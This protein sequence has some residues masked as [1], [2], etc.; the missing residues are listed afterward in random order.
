MPTFEQLQQQFQ[1]EMKDHR[2]LD[3]ELKD[4]AKDL[5]DAA[6]NLKTTSLHSRQQTTSMI[7]GWNSL[8]QSIMGLTQQIQAM[9]LH[10]RSQEVKMTGGLMPSFGGGMPTAPGFGGGMQTRPPVMQGSGM[11][12]GMQMLGGA[13]AGFGFLKDQANAPLNMS[14]FA[15]GAFNVQ[16]QGLLSNL[17]QGSGIGSGFMDPRAM[18]SMQRPSLQAAQQRNFITG[19]ANLPGGIAAD[20]LGGLRTGTSADRINPLTVLSDE[21]Q[22]GQSFGQ[23]SRGRTASRFLGARGGPQRGQFTGQEEIRLG[24]DIR[25]GLQGEIELSKEDIDFFMKEFG[26]SDQMRGKLQGNAVRDFKRSFVALAKEAAEDMRV[27]NMTREQVADLTDKARN[28]LGVD[29]SSAIQRQQLRS[30]IQ[31]TAHLAGMSPQQVQEMMTAGAK[32][33][34]QAG[35]FASTGARSAAQSAGLAGFTVQQGKIGTDLMATVG[36]EG[37]MANLTER[38][39]NKF[40]GGMGGAAMLYGAKMGD[41]TDILQKMQQN[42][43]TPEQMLEFMSSK[44]KRVKNLMKEKG[45]GAIDE[46]ILEELRGQVDMMTS[47]M[48]LS[49]EA[50][51]GAIKGIMKNRYGMNDAEAD[52]WLTQAKAG[53]EHRLAKERTKVEEFDRQKQDAAGRDRSFRRRIEKRIKEG[54]VVGGAVSKFEE[55]QRDIGGMSERFTNAMQRGED[56]SSGRRRVSVSEADRRRISGGE[57]FVGVADPGAARRAGPTLQSTNE[58]FTGVA[59]E[60]IGGA[61]GLMREASGLVEGNVRR[62]MA[63]V[64]AFFGDEDLMRRGGAASAGRAGRVL[65]LVGASDSAQ[66]GD[67]VLRALRDPKFDKFRKEITEVLQGFE[68]GKPLSKV[69]EQRLKRLYEQASKD[70]E[71]KKLIDS[72]LRGAGFKVGEGGPDFG[73]MYQ[74]VGR[75]DF[76]TKGTF[77]DPKANEELGKEREKEISQ[78]TGAQQRK[79][80]GAALSMF[81]QELGGM[82]GQESEELLG[83]DLTGTDTVGLQDLETETEKFLNI[84]SRDKGRLQEL[85][86][87]GGTGRKLAK[88]AAGLGGGDA[89]PEATRKAIDIMRMGGPTGAGDQTEQTDGAKIGGEIATQMQEYNKA[90]LSTLKAMTSAITGKPMP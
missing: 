1:S 13:A 10:S 39:R 20:V 80:A 74:A 71:T 22:R 54:T 78:F 70:P 18:Q 55:A 83:I 4:S 44:H 47:G 41:P 81:S 77:L 42:L 9:V 15:P 5:S 32:R 49:D 59:D 86:G 60:D 19:T 27:L 38:V 87:K 69:D 64:G 30:E 46:G 57:S 26:R 45:P 66:P 68:P 52:A 73:K 72:M 23:G 56:I 50:K 25:A 3:S 75:K 31:A 51:E 43:Q 37:G 84:I 61:A 24:Q 58:M 53:P 36:G 85:A 17:V 79:T 63:T 21:L 76:K 8:Q 65:G 62:G 40:M 16:S 88:L 29:T 48:D 11:G 7:Q 89:T 90:N 34:G 35:L 28:E 14:G 12:L 6:K 2:K 67:K 33:G 82:E